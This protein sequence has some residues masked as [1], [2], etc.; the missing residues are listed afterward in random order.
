LSACASCLLEDP[1]DVFTAPVRGAGVVA[2]KGFQKDQVG[3]GFG[4]I[5]AVSLVKFGKDG[6]AYADVKAGIKKLSVID[7]P[8]VQVLRIDLHQAHVQRMTLGKQI[9]SD[10][11][12]LGAVFRFVGFAGGVVQDRQW[13]AGT[14]HFNDRPDRVRMNIRA[15]GGAERRK[16][17]EA[18]NQ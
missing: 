1:T 16:G 2:G 4:I 11:D 6:R 14:L 8:L 12:R 10:L 17:D 18:G 9:A 15:A 13:I 3:W 5:A 7:S